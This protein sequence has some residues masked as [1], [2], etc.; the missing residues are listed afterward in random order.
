MSTADLQQVEGAGL[1]AVSGEGRG[2]GGVDAVDPVVQL[3]LARRLRIFCTCG[4][5]YCEHYRGGE[6]SV[7][8]GG[9]RGSR[10]AVSSVLM[11]PAR[12]S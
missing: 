3:H 12:R 4:Y 11:A 9:G 6:A 7:G 10:V 8:A 1:A 2:A 5:G